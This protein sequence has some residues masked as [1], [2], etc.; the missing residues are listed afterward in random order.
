MS[1]SPTGRIIPVAHAADGAALKPAHIMNTTGNATF[2]LQKLLEQQGYLEQCGL[3]ATTVNADGTTRLLGS[4]LNGSQDISVLSGISPIFPAVEHGAKMKILAGADL[5]PVQTIYSKRPEIKE[6]KDLVGRNVGVGQLGSLAHQLVVALLLKRGIDPSKVTFAS[7]GSSADMFRAVVAGSVDAAPG[8]I[9]VYKHQADYGVHSL[10]D[11]NMWTEI[12]EHTYQGVF[13]SEE[14]ITNRRDVLVRVLAAYAL[15]YRFI[16]GPDSK[17]AFVKV[18]L[19][20]I[21]SENPERQRQ[22]AIDEWEFYQTYK[23]FAID[24]TLSEERIQ[25]LQE[26]NIKTGV[27]TR[28]LPFDQV[29]DMSLAREALKLIG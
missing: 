12:P 4:I 14:A 16:Q 2:I 5:L 20:A 10:S 17:D 3:D 9:E 21:T 6:V 13:A 24:L 23:P 22:Q 25:Y 15:L 26:L 1:A 7:I 11:A 27:Q 29:A 8:Q 18:T 19:A 28:M